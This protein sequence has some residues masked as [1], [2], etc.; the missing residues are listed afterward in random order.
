MG[1]DKA[2]KFRLENNLEINDLVLVLLKTEGYFDPWYGLREVWLMDKEQM[3]RKLGIAKSLSNEEKRE[4]YRKSGYMM[5]HMFGGFYVGDRQDLIKIIPF[6]GLQHEYSE[7]FVIPVDG[8]KD[9]IRVPYFRKIDKNREI[10]TD[11]EK[12][13]D[14]K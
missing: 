4:I 8:V 1:L 14:R 2:A 11:I 13:L 3:E 12:A 5:V 7:Y 10:F 6:Y 9:I